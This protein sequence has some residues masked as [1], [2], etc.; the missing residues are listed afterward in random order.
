MFPGLCVHVIMLA[1]GSVAAPSLRTPV[2]MS[3]QVLMSMRPRGLFPGQQQQLISLVCAGSPGQHQQRPRGA[4]ALCSILRAPS[5]CFSAGACGSQR[6]A[7][8]CSSSSS[9]AS[10]YSSRIPG[11][12]SL[13]ASAHSQRLP[14]TT[15]TLPHPQALVRQECASSV[16]A[17]VGCT[18]LFGWSHCSGPRTRSRRCG[19][20][21]LP[22]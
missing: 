22:T 19:Y 11:A 6:G 10:G 13:P 17:L 7:R 18:L 9:S 16:V 12:C 2:Q 8:P 5:V 1:S 21:S 20:L 4:T 14:P 3:R 15:T